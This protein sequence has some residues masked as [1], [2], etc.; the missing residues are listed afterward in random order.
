MS[1]YHS[2]Y[3]SIRTNSLLL[4]F[5]KYSRHLCEF[6]G[7]SKIPDSSKF[8]RFKQNFLLDLQLV[9]DRLVDVTVPICQP[10]YS[11]KADMTIFDSCK[12]EAWLTENNPMFAN[13]IIKQ[14]KAYAKAN[15]FDSNYDPYK[16]A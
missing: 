9:F 3:F 1:T 11:V 12:I 15:H 14:L 10:I 2:A 16:A 8:I 6:C 4:V 13:R 7:L 5:L